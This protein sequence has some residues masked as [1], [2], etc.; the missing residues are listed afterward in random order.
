[1]AKKKASSSSSTTDQT[2]SRYFLSQDVGKYQAGVYYTSEVV[3]MP[4]KVKQYIQSISSA[5]AEGKIVADASSVDNLNDAD[6]YAPIDSTTN[7]QPELKGVKKGVFVDGEIQN[8]ETFK[9]DA[10]KISNK[11]RD[12]LASVV[13]ESQE[14]S[15]K[16][17]IA[18][19]KASSNPPPSHPSDSGH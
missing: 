1:M 15:I 10:K 9:Q 14:D 5:E 3:E 13:T 11:L 19:K 18:A 8:L 4:P 2:G 12:K 6:F 16:A 7:E 17:Q